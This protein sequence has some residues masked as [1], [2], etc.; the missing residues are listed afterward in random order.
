[1]TELQRE[2]Q[3]E[4]QWQSEK[5]IRELQIISDSFLTQIDEMK[6]I[7][8][9]Q[10]SIIS[11]QQEAL[12]IYER[13]STNW[14]INI[15]ENQIQSLEK[16]LEK[17]TELEKGLPEQLSKLETRLSELEQQ[18]GGRL[19]PENDQSQGC[20]H[21]PHPSNGKERPAG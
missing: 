14:Q 21:R 4:L 1:M 8:E 17:L 9:A 10:R 12:E 13:I 15:D 20:L 6:Q 19:L 18:L 7:N 16:S 2:L 11:T 5:F 3:R